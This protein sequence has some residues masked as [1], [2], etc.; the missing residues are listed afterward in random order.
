MEIVKLILLALVLIITLPNLIIHAQE[1]PSWVNQYLQSM[2]C[3]GGGSISITQDT[4]SLSINVGVASLTIDL[5]GVRVSNWLIYSNNGQL[6][7]YSPP[8]GTL[9]HSY[10]LYDWIPA[11]NWPG[12]L[13]TSLWGY[14]VVFNNGSVAVVKFTLNV[15]RDQQL[16]GVNLTVIKYLVFCWGKYYLLWVSEIINNGSTTLNPAPTWAPIGYTLADTG[17]VGTTVDN[18]Y[19]AY[20][21]GSQVYLWGPGNWQNWVRY[22]AQDVQWVALINPVHPGGLVLAIKPFNTT[23]SVW[24]ESDFNGLEARIEYPQFLLRPGGSVT[25][26]ALVYGGP[27]NGSQ[28]TE[29]NLTSLYDTCEDLIQQSQFSLSVFT[30]RVVYLPGMAGSIYVNASSNLRQPTEAMLNVTILYLGDGLISSIGQLY[31]SGEVVWSRSLGV[32]LNPGVNTFRVNFTAPTRLGAYVI[33]ASLNVNG[34]STQS[35]SLIAVSTPA[36]RVYVAFVFHDHQGTGYMPNGIYA[37]TPYA[38][39]HVW[40]SELEPYFNYGVYYV[41][42]YL[43]SQYPLVHWTIELSPPLLWQ[44]WYGLNYG[45]YEQTSNGL[46]YIPPLGPMNPYMQLVNETIWMFKLMANRGQV[47]LATSFFDHPIAGF[48]VTYFGPQWLGLLSD[49]ARLGVEVTRLVMGVNSTVFWV[50]EMWWSDELVPMLAKA[51]IKVIVL[52]Q[53]YEYSSAVGELHGIYVPYY[54]MVNGSRLIVLFRDTVISNLLSFTVNNENN[55]GQAELNAR[56]MVVDLVLKGIKN[57]N[58]IVTVATDGENWIIMSKSPPLAALFFNYLLN[59]LNQTQSIGVL[60]T[61]TVSQA[62][63]HA[64]AVYNLT[65]IPP[66]TW[67]GTAA[68]WDSTPTQQLMWSIANE[69]LNCWLQN[70]SRLG[71]NSTIV[72]WMIMHIIDSDH[73]YSSFLDEDYVV[74]YWGP[75]TLKACATGDVPTWVYQ[76]WYRLEMA[77]RPQ[78]LYTLSV[79]ASAGNETVPISIYANEFIDVI[80][81]TTMDAAR[82]K[83]YN[84]SLALIKV[85]EAVGDYRFS[86]WIINGGS[87]LFVGNDTVKVMVNGNVTITAAYS[88]P[89]PPIMSI[90]VLSLL[91]AVV[92]IVIVIT[93]LMHSPRHN[94]P[95]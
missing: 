46:L 8:R 61:V 11:E 34:V 45:I 91:I 31:S 43:L 4:D 24:L 57:P 13:A 29:V 85:P 52:D 83:L 26:V 56:L 51:G 22:M 20:A 62:I 63:E 69:T 32:L 90:V 35:L 86:G 60:E 95:S 49:D 39:Y 94:T 38:F 80:N 48:L 12:T 30:D 73:Y 42:A 84:G 17:V 54:I 79:I 92:V 88:K 76:A 78:P 3:T 36:D 37:G 10:P 58:G 50:P 25:F 65:Y 6:A 81:K 7:A 1:L 66:Q 59:Y 41:Q 18:D 19:Q 53:Q 67:A 14:N 93:A 71:T 82:L 15:T 64:R 9:N 5:R 44:W 77:I 16:G 28:L 47:E 2:Q 55:P 87:V 70:K 33:D 74:K 75:A 23:Y 89:Q 72:E 27:F 40:A 21:N 68:I